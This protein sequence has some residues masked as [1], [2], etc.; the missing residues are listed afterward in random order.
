M[1]KLPVIVVLHK[2]LVYKSLP[3]KLNKENYKHKLQLF[4]QTYKM[5]KIKLVN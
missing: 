4:K 1:I 3:Y 2:D 5:L